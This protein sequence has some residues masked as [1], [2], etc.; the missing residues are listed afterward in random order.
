VTCMPR[1]SFV[2]KSSMSWSFLF[3]CSAIA[4]P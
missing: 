2:F 1:S 4:P 3:F